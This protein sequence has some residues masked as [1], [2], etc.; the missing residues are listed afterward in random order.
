MSTWAPSTTLSPPWLLMASSGLIF[1]TYSDDCARD[2]AARD[3]LRLL[4]SPCCDFLQLFGVREENT[5]RLFPLPALQLPQ[6]C[7]SHLTLG[8]GPW[9]LWCG[10][11]RRSTMT[12]GTGSP[13]RGTSS[14]PACRWTGCHSRSERHRPRVTRAWSCT[15]SCSLVSTGGKAT[16]TS[17]A[18]SKTRPSGKRETAR[19]VSG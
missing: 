12:S 1:Y 13:R 18:G 9:R 14:R 2:L 11:P 17:P 8:T 10:R 5:Q 19:G 15:A 4:F 16:A 6:K 7:P 3:V